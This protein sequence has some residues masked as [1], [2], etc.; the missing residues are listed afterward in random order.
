MAVI[1]YNDPSMSSQKSA[2]SLLAV[3]LS[4]EGIHA[5]P[6]VM[7]LSLSDPVQTTLPG[8]I[9]SY[10]YTLA[11][12]IATD[13]PIAGFV[14]LNLPIYL[15]ELF[16]PF[17]VPA[18]GSVNGTL[19]F[20]VANNAAFGI[21]TFAIEAASSLHDPATVL[22]YVSNMVPASVDVVPEPSTL[23]FLAI[24]VGLLALAHRKSA[25]E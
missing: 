24:G 6:I 20:Q 16:V 15:T 25:N 5:A 7:N 19:S 1:V 11:N 8:S 10:H 14:G 2:L 18:N 4:V 12:S 9:L 3:L 21:Q 13:L 22:S 17:T 23:A